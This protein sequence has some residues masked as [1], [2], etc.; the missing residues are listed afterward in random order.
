MTKQTVELDIPDGYEFVGYHV[1]QKGEHFI[2]S[3]DNSIIHPCRKDDGWYEGRIVVKPIKPKRHVFE[4]SLTKRK[5]GF[6]ELYLN[7]DGNLRQWDC[8][9][10]STSEYTILT[11]VK[12]NENN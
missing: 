1:P 3:Q 12:E 4:E 7:H 9:H 6:N 8:R 10:L 2:N 11:P 5:V